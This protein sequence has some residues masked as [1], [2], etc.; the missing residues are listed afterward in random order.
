[1]LQE[2]ARLRGG[3]QPVSLRSEESRANRTTDVAPGSSKSL[4]KALRILFHLGENGPDLGLTELATQ[5][6]LN[7]STAYRLLNAMEKFGLIEKMGERDRYRL[8]LKLF[9][10][11][12]KA[13]E[14][15]TLRGE[16][17]HLLLQLAQQS[18]ET[19]SL[20][21]PA[22][23]GAV[24]LDR[25]DCADTII[26][27]RTSVGARFQSHCTAVGKAVLAFL[28]EEEIT[29]ILTTDSL[30]RYTPNTITS[31]RALRKNLEKVVRRGYALDEEEL[32]RG[33]SGVAA[34]VRARDGRVLAAVGMAGP[35]NRFRAAE[36]SRKIVLIRKTAASI[37]EG[38][39]S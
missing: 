5:I 19:V 16:A 31:I 10:L 17:H 15:R 11:G 20:A 32:E 14:S 23:G 8:G 6:G 25:V 30:T 1:V 26:T 29:A 34:P 7:K 4:Q 13:L 22:V 27:V 21:V 28:P 2:K 3:A 9:E 33:L 36:L 38:L 12:N 35:T 39:G 24:C 18:R 37:A